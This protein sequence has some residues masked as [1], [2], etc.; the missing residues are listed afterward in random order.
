M[1]VFGSNLDADQIATGPIGTGGLEPEQVEAQH[2]AGAPGS[3]LDIGR[4]IGAHVAVALG[5]EGCR[6]QKVPTA[7]GTYIC[8]CTFSPGLG[9]GLQSMAASWSSALGHFVLH[10]LH[11]CSASCTT[12]IKNMDPTGA[13]GKIAV[14]VVA[15]PRPRSCSER[16]IEHPCRI[17]WPVVRQPCQICIWGCPRRILSCTDDV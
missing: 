17:V 6:G 11:P 10:Q 9:S 4:G 16:N 8:N 3:S 1:R 15:G 7:Q 12:A 13:D 14:D 2:F 5:V